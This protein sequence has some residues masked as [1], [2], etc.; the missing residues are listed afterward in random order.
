[1]PALAGIPSAFGPVKP[2]GQVPGLGGD[3]LSRHRVWPARHVSGIIA[4]SCGAPPKSARRS[5]VGRNPIPVNF[6]E[7]K[8][9]VM[10]AP[11]PAVAPESEE[12]RYLM[13]AGGADISVREVSYGSK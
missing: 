4:V 11:P 12:P 2:A 10:M 13:P 5:V 6:D 3:T 9:R 8:A 1:M 7:S